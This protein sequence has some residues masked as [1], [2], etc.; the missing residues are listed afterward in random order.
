M[1][2]GRC[3]I[4]QKFSFVSGTE[5]YRG[6]T[7]DN[8]L[9]SPKSGEIHFH[10]RIPEYYDGF[11]PYA[12]FLTLPGY[13][14]LYFQGVGA[15]LRQEEF[16]FEAGTYNKHMIIV[17]PQLKDWGEISANQI[18]ALMEFLLDHYNIDT[19]RVYANGYADG[20]ETMS[21]VL[22]KRP[23]LFTAYLH[24][25]SQWDGAYE[26]VI[27]NRIPIYFVVGRDDEYYGSEPTIYAY[28]QM[29]SFY[30]EQGMSRDEI[31]KV[32]VLDIK[33]EDYFFQRGTQNQHAGGRLIAYDEEIMRWLIKS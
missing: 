19:K 26:T 21:L 32:L 16:A 24:C 7:I 28:N 6:F 23:D 2:N 11:D 15:N 31:N 33:E 10:I 22:E 13:S 12:L 30:K 20:G 25:C 4:I 5:I 9:S 18:I 3:V 1:I 17:A 14:G 27:E 8:V 29:F